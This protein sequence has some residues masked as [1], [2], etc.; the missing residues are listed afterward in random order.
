MRHRMLVTLIAHSIAACAGA[1]TAKPSAVAPPA[2]PAP[3]AISASAA[4]PAKAENE[5][6]PNDQERPESASN[7]FVLQTAN[8][9]TDVRA[10]SPSNLKPTAHEAA[11][12]FTVIDK[13]KG[14]I[15]GIIIALTAAD[16]AKFYT[17]ET[18]AEGHAE[19]LVP[20]GQ[21]YELVYL[22]LGRK[23]IAATVGVTNEPNQSIRL[24]LRYKRFEV[25][26]AKGAGP[27]PVR[28]LVLSGVTFDTAKA[29]IRPESY[30]QLDGVVEYMQHKAGARIEISG[31]TDNVGNARAN[32][33]LSSKRA[34][35]CRDYLVARGID[36]SRIEAVGYGDERPIASND[37][38]EGRQQNR[39]IEAAEL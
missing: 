14:P 5:P 16:G 7:E 11:M 34:Q 8:A 31:H 30:A 2:A 26:K 22:S 12:R 28:G 38:E 21:K 19:V 23:D 29:T 37:S 13:D 15:P 33:A 36:G 24:T 35:A 20:V 6:P 9:K 3:D 4:A 1:Q 39:R 32:K 17:E 10:R 27:E 18:D 25:P